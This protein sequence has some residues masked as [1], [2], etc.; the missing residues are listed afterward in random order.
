M[1][2][3]YRQ[4]GQYIRPVDVRNRDLSVTL[5]L[6][7]SIAKQFIPS[8]ANTVGT[9]MSNYKIIRKGQFAYGPVTSRNGDKISIALLREEECIISQAYTA[10]EVID[11]G[12]LDPEY[13]MLWFSRPEFDRYARFHSHGSVREIFGWDDLCRVELPVPDIEAQR[14]IASSVTSIRNRKNL[15]G[16]LIRKLQETVA[17]YYYSVFKERYSKESATWPTSNICEYGRIG[18]GGTPDTNI[19][20]FWDGEIPFFT[21]SDASEF[22]YT[23]QKT[24]K[25]L[26]EAGVSSCS[27]KIY[28]KGTVF[29]TARGTVGKVQIAARDMAMNQSCYAFIPNSAVPS[30]MAYM[31]LKGIVEELKKSAHGAVFSAIITKDILNISVLIP[32]LDVRKEIKS[33]LEKLFV[34]IQLIQQENEVLIETEA[35]FIQSLSS[36]KK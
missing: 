28:S 33:V 24:E 13:L 16:N 1:K 18:G 2:S 22:P 14:K 12:T 15:N 26:T 25:T 3:K 17:T 7:V 32:P 23:N 30:Y 29:L 6:G 8:I 27:T 34:F 36:A 21:P 20:D 10:F 5:L 31:V 11:T 19:P 4:L 35:L 9:D